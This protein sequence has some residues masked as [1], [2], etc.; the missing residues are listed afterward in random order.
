MKMT[1]ENHMASNWPRLLKGT[2]AFFLPAMLLFGGMTAVILIVTH[3]SEM[4]ATRAKELHTCH[5]QQQNIDADIGQISSDLAILTNARVLEHLWDE[6]GHPLPSLLS[7]LKYSFLNFAIRRR[8][9]DQIRLLVEEGMEIAMVNYNQGQPAIV[10]DEQ[11]QNKK[12]R[13]YFEDSFILGR[14]EVFVS[15]LDLN[16]EHGRIEQ[17]L[18]PMIRF[19]TPVFDQQGNKRG[20]LLLNYFGAKLITRFESISN[21]TEQSQ[22]MLLNS[23]GYWLK[24]PARE[25]EWGFMYPDRKHQTFVNKYPIVWEVIKSQEIGQVETAE[26]LFTFATVYPLMKGQFSSTGSGEAYAPSKKWVQPTQYFWKIVS[27]VPRSTLTARQNRRLVYGAMILGT[28]T[29]IIFLGSGLL[30]NAVE[31]RKQAEMDLRSAYSRLEQQVEERTKELRHSREDLRITLNSIGDA[32]IAT[33][34]NGMVVRINQVALDLTGLTL[35]EAKGEALDRVFQIV[36]ASTREKISTAVTRVLESD[37]IISLPRQTVLI[38]RDGREYRITASA[39]PIR[40]AD[41][42]ITGVVLVFRDVTEEEKTKEELLKI[43]KLE[44]VGVLAGGIAHDFNNILAAILGNI[45]LARMSIDST[46]KAY[47][48]LKEAEKASLRARDLTQQLL[49]FSQ[50]GEPV[51]KT[52]PIGKLITES[53]DFVLHGS[54]VSS[55]F[56]IPDN[57]WLADFDAGQISQVIQNLV[58]NAKHAMPEGGEIRIDCAN[59]K[60][61]TSETNLNLPDKSFIRIA[62][63]DNGCGIAPKHLEKIFDPYFTTKQEGSGLGLAISHSII[64][65]HNGH[66]AVRS[67]MGKGTIFTIYLPAAQALRVQAPTEEASEPESVRAR[68]LVMDDEPLVQDIL[69]HMLVRLGHDVLQAKDGQEAIKLFCQH[70]ASDQPVDVIIMDLTIPGGMGGKET[71]REILKIAP[72]AKVVVS[73]GYSNNPV[74]ANYRQYGFKAAI[75]KPFS[76]AEVNK[77]LSE[78]LAS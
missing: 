52:S 3:K 7:D 6:D 16:I 72:E 77:T 71:I 21:P 45:E 20:I 28:L 24:G 17:P 68:I 1:P 73:S 4:K 47:P 23:D 53:A 15:P 64:S 34:K 30:A 70:R 55:R 29:I 33:D 39:A 61:I 56:N 41:R 78:V 40:D 59:V 22:P 62:V 19:A 60:D 38:S 35:Q 54:S 76:L 57:L 10:P 49:T 5:I 44:S 9:Y 11:L 65:K 8:L 18:K 69:R 12:G 51:K 27:F 2:L 31:Q 58:L 63:E 50:R 43:K 37:R 74:M 48:L 32:V 75:A 13:Y 66:I 26:G 14:E 25:I 36:D 46:S 42:T 67:I